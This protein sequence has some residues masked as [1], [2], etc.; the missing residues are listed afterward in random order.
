MSMASL[1]QGRSD[2]DEGHRALRWHQVVNQPEQ[3]THLHPTPQMLPA[4]ALLGYPCDLGVALNHGRV[5]AAAGPNALRKMLANLPWDING[6]LV[7]AGDTHLQA[8]LA[9][10]QHY[11]RQRL[12]TLL[13]SHAAVLALGGGHDIALGSYL[14]LA[15]SLPSDSVIGI[16]N[17][18]AH[19]DLRSPAKGGSS[20]TPF[21]QIAQ[22]CE[23]QDRDFHYACLGASQAANTP[24]L[25]DYAKQNN[26][27]IL[28]DIDFTLAN[29]QALLSPFLQYIDTLYVTVCMDAFAASAAPGVSA[30]AALGIDPLPVIKLINWLGHAAEQA[31][32]TW[33]LADIAELNPI[34]DEQLKTARLA[35]RI[36]FELASALF[37]NPCV[38]R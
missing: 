34:Y 18:D 15:D 9:Q 11:Y 26:V 22:W 24:A 10:T 33:K 37:I 23:A 20:G 2:A 6:Q 28:P 29:A 8:T 38:K 1:W 4:L 25:Y 36:G 7:D 3:L 30:P 16:I 17:I 21:R 12:A 14:A 13:S 19:L 35:S 27:H 5:G 32:V 31:S